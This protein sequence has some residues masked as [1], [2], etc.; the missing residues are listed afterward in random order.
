[1]TTQAKPA[2]TKPVSVSLLRGPKQNETSETAFYRK[3]PRGFAALACTHSLSQ[4]A[5][6]FRLRL[7]RTV[8]GTNIA[9]RV[10]WHRRTISATFRT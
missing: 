5:L 4:H 8:A 10:R 3:R 6:R 2:Q 7:A 1:M 9:A